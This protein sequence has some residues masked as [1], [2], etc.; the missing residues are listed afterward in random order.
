[1]IF[2]QHQQQQLTILA[3][4][5]CAAVA[6]DPVKPW[7]ITRLVT[8]SLPYRG[9]AACHDPLNTIAV[10]IHDANYPGLNSTGLPSVQCIAKFPYCS[11]PYHKSFNCTEVPYRTWSFSFFQPD[12][13]ADSSYWNPGQSFVL[14]FRLLLRERGVWYDGQATFAVGDNL[15]G[16]CSA[17]GICSFALKEMTP[18]YVNPMGEM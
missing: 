18:F 16:M 12:E 10:E 1:M 3:L 4:S 8:S 2:Q 17:A 14:C 9:E 7:E 15:R 6:H 13:H 5:A 11:P